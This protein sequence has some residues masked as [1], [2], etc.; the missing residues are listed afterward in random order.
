MEFL[1]LFLGLVPMILLQSDDG[2]TTATPSTD[3]HDDWDGST[4]QPD[5]G[6]VTG[7]AGDDTMFGGLLADGPTGAVDSGVADDTINGLGGND[8]IQA[9][10]GNDDIDGGA[11]EDTI[12]GGAGDDTLA[13]GPGND[14]LSGGAGTD[15]A[16]YSGAIG[17]VIVNLA[18]G[19]ASGDGTDTLSGIENLNGSGQGDTLEG[20]ANDNAIFGNAGDDT[21]LGGDGAD[22]LDGG[23]D[24][25]R[26]IGG[27]GADTITTGA[28]S[29]VV[30]VGDGD[31]ITDFDPAN[32]FIDLTPF[33]SSLADAQNDLDTNGE[34]TGAGPDG[35]DLV[36]IIGSD[37]TTANTGLSNPALIE[38]EFVS[39]VNSN[40]QG[41]FVFVNL[42]TVNSTPGSSYTYLY[43]WGDGNTDTLTNPFHLYPGQT[44][45]L[46][47]VTL[48]ATSTTDPSD[49][50]TYVATID[51]ATGVQTPV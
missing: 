32:D 46:V 7:T 24:D 3:I 33:Y 12:F 45:G 28:G 5:D 27:N 21:L 14:S 2:G 30:T 25:D 34:L 35:I 9:G 48:T 23:A 1:L 41:S 29:D 31:T 51:L 15:T 20:D 36:G 4:A 47:T 8:S 19:T 26:L 13:G 44:S 42:V 38:V 39:Q 22:S 10:V 6:T 16:D 17:S 37:L 49:T 11:G 40:A 18:N 43:D 50:D